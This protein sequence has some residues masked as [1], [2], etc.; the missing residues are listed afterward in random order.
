MQSPTFILIK[1]SQRPYHLTTV[2][3]LVIFVEIEVIVFPE[4]ERIF[5]RAK[6]SLDRL[7]KNT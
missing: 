4:R 3:T 5:M 7:N 1:A 2:G 6:K